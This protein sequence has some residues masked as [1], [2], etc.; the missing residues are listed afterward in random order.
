MSVRTVT[1]DVLR[2]HALAQ[3]GAWTTL[4]EERL[5]DVGAALSTADARDALYHLLPAHVADCLLP[6][7]VVDEASLACTVLTAF[8][9]GTATR[10][11]GDVVRVFTT[12]VAPRHQLGLLDIDPLVYVQSLDQELVE[13]QSG[14]DRV[15]DEIGPAYKAAYIDPEKR[16]RDYV[17]R[18]VRIAC[19]NVIVAL[20]AIAQDSTFD[21]LSVLA[22]QTCEVPHVATHEGNRALAALT[23]CDAFARGGTMEI[24]FDRPG[25][26]DHEGKTYS[27]TGHPEM[28]VP[29]SLRRYGRAVGVTLGADNPAS[30]SPPEARE[31]FLSVTP[32]PPELRARVLEAT[33]T[34]GLAPERACYALLSQVWREVE[35]D[36]LL[37]T[38]EFA[39]SILAGGAD[40]TQRSQ[41]QAEAD[42]CRSA[43]MVGMYYRRL[44]G[45]DNA[46]GG[47]D[48]VRVIEDVT[49]GVTWSISAADAT[50]SYTM[51]RPV[52]A[53]WATPG[54][55]PAASNALTV[56]PRVHVTDRDLELIDDLTAKGINAALLLPADVREP[57][58]GV[59][60]V[61]CPDRLADLDHFIEGKLLTSRIS[62]G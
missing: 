22:W 21:G 53:P 28:Q 62:R 58:P 42:A 36:M 29:A 11:P 13:R 7:A 12:D 18:P 16:P 34:R 51:S 39:A 49:S 1:D 57:G 6:L 25:R 27:Y 44:D 54:S 30:I 8:D 24:R 46:T 33:A 55:S 26:V 3:L 52:A 5:L 60:V 14:R 32:M 23:L 48:G 35:L 47:S 56:L 41:R 9:A 61:R 10:S 20:A 38:S 2:S 59:L 43:L 40:W 17:V 15:L 50:I 45:R 37:A 4:V 31:L 19:Q